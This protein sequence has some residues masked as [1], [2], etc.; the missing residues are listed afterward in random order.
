METVYELF[1][2]WFNDQTGVWKHGETLGL[3]SSA[4]AAMNLSPE[5][6]SIAEPANWSGFNAP[7]QPTRYYGTFDKENFASYV[8][9]VVQ[10]TLVYSE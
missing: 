7:N 8:R 9:F 2:E 1:V 3:F 5:F 6:S 4:Q 10:S